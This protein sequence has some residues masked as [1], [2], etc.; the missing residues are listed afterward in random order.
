[1]NLRLRHCVR[2]RPCQGQVESGDRG[3]WLPGVDGA[4]L[5]VVVDGLGHGPQASIAGAAAIVA[6]EA[7]VANGVDDPVAVLRAMHVGL[8]GTRGA[9]ATVCRISNDRVAAAGVG[10]VAIRSEGLSLSVG[11]APGILGS[12]LGKVQG[13]DAPRGAG[14]VALFS[15]GLSS[16][17]DLASV[18]G[19][20][21]EVA[22]DA[23]FAA[24][25][26]SHDDATLLLAELG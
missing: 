18:R 22:A 20:A 16:R 6:V 23:L 19:L 11:L 25:A 14:R 21:L 15:D 8:R 5:L 1:M 7:S 4:V 24:H 12:R 9:G 3:L 17:L 26:V 10:N 13:F 2:D